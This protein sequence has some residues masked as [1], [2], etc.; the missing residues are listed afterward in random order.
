MTIGERISFELKKRGISQNKLSK[1]AQISQSGLS[2]IISGA[3]SPKESTLNAIASALGLTMSELLEDT[4]T[5]K[6]PAVPDGL[7]TALIDLLCDLSPSEEA[8]VRDFVAGLK[9]NRTT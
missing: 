7:D 3:V 2:S 8:R 4:E 5:K 6:E 1:L 9:A